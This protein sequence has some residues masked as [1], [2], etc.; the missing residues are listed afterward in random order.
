MQQM[1]VQFLILKGTS[2]FDIGDPTGTGSD[3]SNADVLDAEIVRL[4][5]TVE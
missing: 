4:L 2:A 1:T 3:T 5:L